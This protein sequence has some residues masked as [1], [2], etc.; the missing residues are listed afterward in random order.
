MNSL[1]HNLADLTLQIEIE[2]RC[3][4]LWEESEPK[5]EAL[6]SLVPF[7]H[8]T[9]EFHQ[10][11]QWVFLPKMKSVIETETELPSSSDIYSLAEYAFE[12]LTQDTTRL[13]QLIE[14]F[15]RVINR[16]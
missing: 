8:D 11:L 15:D 13:L 9:L 6:Q 3:L 14:V 2:M 7:C 10:W 16:C 1:I 12:K 5:A 4:K